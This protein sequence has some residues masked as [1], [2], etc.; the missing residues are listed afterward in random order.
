[1]AK[2]KGRPSGSRNRGYFYRAGRGWYAKLDGKFV[3]LEYPNGDRRR[4]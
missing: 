1:M 3:P 2:G 4:D